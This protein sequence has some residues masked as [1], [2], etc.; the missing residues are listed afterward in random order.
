MKC[1]LY[2]GGL[3]MFLVVLSFLAMLAAV[4]IVL[5][6]GTSG[7]PDQMYKTAMKEAPS[8]PALFSFTS[9]RI[10][11]R[12]CKEWKRDIEENSL[13]SYLLFF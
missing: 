7:D 5:Y 3:V 10:L 4:I 12:H 1:N 6:K 9:R 2:E 13:I 8:R 11:G